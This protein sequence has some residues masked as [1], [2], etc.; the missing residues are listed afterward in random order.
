MESFDSLLS[1]AHE[2]SYSLVQPAIL[3][4]PKSL[5]SPQEETAYNSLINNHK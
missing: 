4:Q 5:L 2:G 3:Q 1:I